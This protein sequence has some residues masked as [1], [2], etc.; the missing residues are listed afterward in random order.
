ML[1]YYI[2]VP[3]S[4]TNLTVELSGGSGDVDLYTRFDAE[5]ETRAYDCRSNNDGNSE[6]C[7][8]AS[9]EAGRWYIGL[10]GYKDFSGVSLTAS[11]ELEDTDTDTDTDTDPDPEPDPEPE[12]TTDPTPDSDSSMSLLE[13]LLNLIAQLLAL[14]DELLP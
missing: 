6:S 2:D 14:L 9:P 8:E 5:P 11:Y 4:A 7:T 12:P 10:H 3:E 1:V 13:T